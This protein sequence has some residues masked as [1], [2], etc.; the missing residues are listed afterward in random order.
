MRI[1]SLVCVC[2]YELCVFRVSCVCV[3][4]LCVFRVW[5]V[6][7]CVCVCVYELCV[8]RVWR[9]SLPWGSLS[10]RWKVG[11]R[12]SRLDCPQA[13]VGGPSC[14]PCCMC[15][16]GCGGPV[17][18]SVSVLHIETDWHPLCRWWRLHHCGHWCTRKPGR[19]SVSQPKGGGIGAER[20]QFIHTLWWSVVQKEPPRKN[21]YYYLLKLLFLLTI[22]TSTYVFFFFL[23][24]D[25]Q[26]SLFGVCQS[27]PT[28]LFFLWMH[29]LVQC[30]TDTIGILTIG[31]SWVGLGPRS[32][33]LLD[34][35]HAVAC[36]PCF[37]QQRSP[38]G[39]FVSSWT[40]QTALL[41]L[42]W[43]EVFQAQCS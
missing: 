27:F 25:K 38:R 13:A 11:C 8:F 31:T 35:A 32:S 1:P 7:V 40:L 19:G 6:C 12:M 2:V 23:V 4:E 28:P 34:T 18:P 39:E 41:W 42:C 37:E 10:T 14:A 43:I 15:R 5:C 20:V 22:S 36:D 17:V 26:I 29:S 24:L 3:Y 16:E 21:F 9:S 30:F 33:Q